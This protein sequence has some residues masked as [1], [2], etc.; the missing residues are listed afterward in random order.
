VKPPIVS[1]ILTIALTGFVL[2]GPS[3]G[4]GQN[5]IQVMGTNAILL[6]VPVMFAVLGLFPAWGKFPAVLMLLWGMF[7]GGWLYIAIG[8]LM[9]VPSNWREAS[10]ANRITSAVCI[11]VIFALAVVGI[12]G[13]VSGRAGPQH[14]RSGIFKQTIPAPENPQPASTGPRR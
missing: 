9:L 11:A 13:R 8:A 3:Y 2:F 1:L 10:R 14:E 4:S 6:L 12:V 7:S 5:A